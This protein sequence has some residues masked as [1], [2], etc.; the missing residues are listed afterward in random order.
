[1]GLRRQERIAGIL[2]DTLRG[3]GAGRDVYLLMEPGRRIEHQGTLARALFDALVQV[4][5]LPE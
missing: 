5:G 2:S 4:V 3:E 1:M